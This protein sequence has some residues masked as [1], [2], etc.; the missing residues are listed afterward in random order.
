M[1][2]SEYAPDIDFDAEIDQLEREQGLTFAALQREAIRSALCHSMSILTGGPGT[3]KTTT[4]NAI[5]T[6]F[7]GQ[8][9]KVALAA[10]TGR[11]AKRMSEL[12]G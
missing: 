11:A 9:Q 7:E 5:I 6:L 8:R 1:K 10:P 12:T 4:L 3:G 2:L